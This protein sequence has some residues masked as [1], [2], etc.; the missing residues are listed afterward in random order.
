MLFK[1]PFF[2]THFDPSN[3]AKPFCGRGKASVELGRKLKE[4]LVKNVRSTVPGFL[5][6]NN[7]EPRTTSSKV[8]KLTK[9][10][11][12]K[13]APPYFHLNLWPHKQPHVGS[14]IQAKKCGCMCVGACVGL[15]ACVRVLAYVCRC[16][17][18]GVCA[19]GCL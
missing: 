18:V 16:L 2:R 13:K 1:L 7:F 8:F 9:M 10:C 15:R 19:R 17:C 6:K 4:L 12:K 14:N 5:I 3:N 11:R